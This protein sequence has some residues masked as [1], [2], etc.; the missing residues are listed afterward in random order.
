MMRNV[1][2]RVCESQI[3]PISKQEGNDMAEQEIIMKHVCVWFHNDEFDNLSEVVRLF[4]NVKLSW[5][6]SSHQ[7][8]AHMCSARLKKKE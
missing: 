3:Q 1:N 8:V 2:V 5:S 7:P 4:R 6:L